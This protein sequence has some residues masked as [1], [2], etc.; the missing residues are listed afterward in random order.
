MPLMKVLLYLGYR[1][2]INGI[3]RIV[4][5]PKRLIPAIFISLLVVQNIMFNP[6]FQ[7]DSD[8]T[9]LH[10]DFVSIPPDILWSG[11]FS[12]LSLVMIQIIYS[13]FSEGRLAF[14]PPN[15]DF[16]FPSPINRRTVLIFKLFGDY[17]KY[18]FF[19]LLMFLF[20]VPSL[21][22]LFGSEPFPSILVSW[23]AAVLLI[24]LVMNIT[25]IISIITSAGVQRFAVAKRIVRIA[26]FLMLVGIAVIGVIYFAKS[27][28]PF[29]SLVGAVRSGFTRTVMAP[30]AWCTD[31][32][33][34]PIVG[35]SHGPAIL[36]LLGIGVLSV[37]SFFVL[38]ARNEN[39]YESSLAISARMARIKDARDRGDLASVVAEA[40]RGRG[41]RHRMVSLVPPFG[42]G[43]GAL[44]WKILVTRLRTSPWAVVIFLVLIPGAAASAGA[45]ISDPDILRLS[46]VVI[47]YAVWMVVSFGWQSLQSEFRQV[48]IVKALPDSGMK[49]VAVQVFTQWLGVLGFSVIAFL[50]ID[51]FIPQADPYL[52][53]LLVITSVTGAFACLS[54]TSI[55]AMAYPSKTKDKLAMTIPGCLSF[56]I[57]SLAVAPAATI[58]IIAGVMK[59]DLVVISILLVVTNSLVAWGAI[60]IA[61]ALFRNSDPND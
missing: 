12:I 9:M 43:A 60:A 51:A 27:G 32:I 11:V 53:A 61:G 37:I 14:S 20:A 7:S 4:T 21:Y 44:I 17:L 33:V 22:R 3:K 52:L 31:L 49:I 56:A 59:V 13:A 41:R 55:V 47:P 40:R 25:H 19:A 10:H 1:Q 29:S 34:F 23:L 42:R 6:V 28:D 50:S 58:A 54:A 48:E 2:S 36:K 8:N 57:I 39:F 30:I 15:V 24:A 35:G 45:F 5:S 16:L 38:I 46:P 26:L 18:G